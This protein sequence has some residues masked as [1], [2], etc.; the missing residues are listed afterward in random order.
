MFIN[1]LVNF[2]KTYAQNLSSEPGD[3]FNSALKQSYSYGV[4]SE[5]ARTAF[6][7]VRGLWR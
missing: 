7:R 1:S 3:S 5:A 6:I 4:S 2:G